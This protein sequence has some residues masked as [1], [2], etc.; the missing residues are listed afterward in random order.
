MPEISEDL[1]ITFF[2]RSTFLTIG[3]S[4][5]ALTVVGQAYY[6]PWIYTNHYFDFGLA[7]YLP[8]ITGTL[9]A[10]F[11]PIGF[12][13]K[14]PSKIV[15]STTGVTIG[16]GLYEI[17][18]PVLHTGIFDWQDMIAAIVTGALTTLAFKRMILIEESKK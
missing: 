11:L 6:R 8:S 2:T 14:F 16:V 7:N 4:A 10:I 13:K 9:T 3:F 12:S 1:S 18:Q 17:L 5:F 15:E